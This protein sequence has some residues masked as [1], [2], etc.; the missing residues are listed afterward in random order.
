MESTTP[1][2]DPKVEPI[3]MVLH[4][5]KC[6]MQ[7]I[8]KPEVEIERWENALA[9]SSTIKCTWTNPPHRSHL[10]HG[11]GTIWRPADV[12]TT[13]VA[14]ITTK[15]KAD[16]WEP[17]QQ[18]V[19]VRV[20]EGWLEVIERMVKG[21]DHLAELARQWEPDYSSGADRKGWVLAKN[22]RDEAVDLL[23]AAQAKGAA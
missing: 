19:P 5:P 2:P 3:P 20:P 12:P 16:T 1:A 15:G 13:G 4:C 23:T 17:G 11:C 6:G 9:A 21:I 14:S 18:G 7:H 8:D 10:C 22:A